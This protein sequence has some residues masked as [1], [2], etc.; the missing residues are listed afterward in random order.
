MLGSTIALI[1][2][3][4]NSAIAVEDLLTR[5]TSTWSEQ[6]VAPYVYTSKW[7]VFDTEKA[8]KSTGQKYWTLC[9]IIADKWGNPSW[10]ADDSIQDEFFADYIL[11]IRTHGG[12]VIV[13]FGGASGIELSVAEKDVKQLA[14]KYQSVIDKYGLTYIDIDIEGSAVGDTK[15]IDRRSKALKIVKDNNKKLIL[16]YTLATNTDGLTE[17]N[18]YIL[19]SAKSAGLKLDG[20]D[21]LILVVNIMAMDYGNVA[22]GKFGMG[23]YA[24]SAAQGLRKQLIAQGMADTQVGITPMIGQNDVD[25]E[26]FQLDD[27]KEVAAW[28]KKN[29]YVRFLAFWSMNRDNSKKGDLFTSTKIK[30]KDYEFLTTFQS[31]S[32]KHLELEI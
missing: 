28:A 13:S 1:L 32:G 7:G 14:A 3:S 6:I 22:N 10:N 21:L 5:T 4:L 19:K 29:E 20:N 31:F 30:Q 12:D 18:L 26:V 24:I 17:D 15:S 25:S 11:G 8:F 2:A 23:G 27:A 9:F 16:S